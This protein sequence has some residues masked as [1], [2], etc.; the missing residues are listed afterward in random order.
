MPNWKKI[1][2]SGSN[3]QISALTLDAAGVTK[4]AIDTSGNVTAA[5]TAT[6]GS[7]VK[8]T[9]LILG[10]TAVTSTAAELNILDGVTSTTAELNILDGV[11]S[12]AAELNVLDGVTSTAAEINKLDGFTGDKDDL[13]YAKDLK[14]T[15]VTATE[16]DYLDGV[17]SAI[18][19]Q[20][21]S[22]TSNV[23]GNL[24]V[25]ANGTSLTITTAN[26]SNISIPEATTSAWGAMSDGLV[27]AI[28]ANTAKE[29]NVETDD[30]SS[31]T[32]GKLA[33][34][35]NEEA[36]AGNDATKALTP[37]SGTAMAAA[38]T[39]SK[40][41]H[42]LTAPT[43]A[44]AM[45]S[46]KITGVTDPTA[47]QDASTKAY[48]DARKS[49][50]RNTTFYAN[51]SPFI[52]NSLYFGHTTGNQPF[53]WNDPQ[54]IGGDPLTVS[55]FTISDDDQ[56]WGM[57][58]PYNISKIEILCGLRPGGTHTDQFSL[59]LYT[60]SRITG[61]VANI[62]LTRVAQNGVNFD[63]SGRYTNNDLTHTADINA[64]TMIYVGVG[65]NTSS[66][67]AKNAPGYMSITITQ[68]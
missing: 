46:Q 52:Q 31:E 30:A 64:G 27:S 13:I 21:D 16:F 5:G 67:V 37:R 45:N 22:K 9:G 56:R 11:T 44:L 26:G 28:A 63:G 58:I 60:A 43:A 62:T 8:T 19:T 59:V 4:A 25:V 57:I 20:I 6:F 36:T 32:K 2:T 40:K 33:L 23:V 3:I 61:N 7:T 42:E 29:T 14:A 49:V 66:P 47:A 54:A 39:V 51:D 65:T 1:L 18:Q 12:T 41:I 53:N 15:G 35:T 24:G 10:S 55:S 17:T 34:A 68:R 50:L 48:V 38:V